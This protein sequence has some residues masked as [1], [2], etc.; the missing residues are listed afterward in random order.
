MEGKHTYETCGCEKCNGT[1]YKGRIAANE[2]LSV[3]DEIKD[4]IISEGS[5]TDIRDAAYRDGFRPL[6]V[7]AF[8]KVLEG[9]TTLEEVKKKLAY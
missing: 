3:T 8:N 2:I 7:D 1:G 9:H 5:I 6:I 4:L